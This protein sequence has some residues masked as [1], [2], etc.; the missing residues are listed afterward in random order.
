MW[1]NSRAKRSMLLMSIVVLL[2]A[3]SLPVAFAQK[4]EVL[5]WS[6][7]AGQPERWVMD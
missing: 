5:F 6:G 3:F 1:S 2:V 7:H 4:S